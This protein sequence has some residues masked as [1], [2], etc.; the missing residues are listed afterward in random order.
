M[1][2][3]D[4]DTGAIKLWCVRSLL[5]MGRAHLPWTAFPAAVVKFIER[6]AAW[7]SCGVFC[8]ESQYVSRNVI[9]RLEAILHAYLLLL[10]QHP[11]IYSYPATVVKRALQIP[12]RKD[13]ALNKKESSRKAEALL[14]ALDDQELL[15]TFHAAD[16]TK[17]HN[18]ADTYLPYVVFSSGGIK[19][20][21]EGVREGAV[22][23]PPA[24]TS[25]STSSP[26]LPSFGGP[27]CSGPI[28]VGGAPS[29]PR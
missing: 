15:R 20:I 12:C 24:S 9:Q 22:S 16:L 18:L 25:T 17:K 6:N 7:F 10:P 3:Y 26:R 29:A 23:T 4:G 21:R 2:V 28:S 27:P 11:Q 13:W 19:G 1:L 14:L 8:I 5:P